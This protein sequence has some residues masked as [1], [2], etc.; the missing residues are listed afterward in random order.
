MCTQS[1]INVNGKNICVGNVKQ[2][3]IELSSCKYSHRSKNLECVVDYKL[4][5]NKPINITAGKDSVYY[6]GTN[7]GVKGFLPA[8]YWSGTGF[9][10]N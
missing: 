7:I 2:D 4:G 6:C 9:Y 8:L 3:K 5:S 10:C 1:I